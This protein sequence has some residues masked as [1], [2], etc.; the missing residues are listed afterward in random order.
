MY[1]QEYAYYVYTSTLI[2][3]GEGAL[4]EEKAV[5]DKPSLTGTDSSS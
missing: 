2:V 4:E 5:P 3:V 1:I